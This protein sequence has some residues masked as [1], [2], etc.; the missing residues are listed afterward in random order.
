MG[1]ELTCTQVSKAFMVHRVYAVP[2]KPHLLQLRTLPYIVKTRP[3]YSATLGEMWDQMTTQSAQGTHCQS[4]RIKHCLQITGQ[5]KD[6]LNCASHGGRSPAAADAGPVFL[7]QKEPPP[8]RRL[9]RV[10]GRFAETRGWY[11][12]PPSC[13]RR[14]ATGV[15]GRPS[16][17]RRFPGTW[18]S[19]STPLQDWP[20]CC[21]GGGACT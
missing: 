2:G 9:D 18:S 11:G 19:T 7:H 12:T 8:F 20:R 21:H 6:G 4:K 14:V 10:S 13:P 3:D 15:A 5:K 17:V 1:N 16:T